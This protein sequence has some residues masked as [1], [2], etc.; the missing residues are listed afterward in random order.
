MVTPPEYA[1]GFMERIEL[2]LG[3][4][5]DARANPEASFLEGSTA[6]IDFR[7]NK[8]IPVP[9]DDVEGW[10]DTTFG[11]IGDGAQFTSIAP[12]HFRIER[13]LDRSVG[14]VVSIVDEN[15][16]RTIPL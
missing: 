9:E 4:G 3:G 5:T 12:D 1:S 11:E 14:S 16:I 8:P 7:L 15:G 10:I 2:D 13:T 6:V